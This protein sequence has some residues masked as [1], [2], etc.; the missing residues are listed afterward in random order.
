MKSQSNITL[1]L[2]ITI[3]RALNLGPEFL[4]LIKNYE[5]CKVRIFAG[6]VF[7][8]GILDSGPM[9]INKNIEPGE[10]PELSTSIL[11]ESKRQ[12]FFTVVLFIK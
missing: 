1:N 5:Y 3:K 12:L 9:L 11:N 6:L 7:G 10:I 8:L 4:T 2:T